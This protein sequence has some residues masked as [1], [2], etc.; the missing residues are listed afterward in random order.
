MSANDARIC[1]QGI[2][3]HTCLNENVVALEGSDDDLALIGSEAAFA[4][5]TPQSEVDI[6]GG[7]LH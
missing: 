4:K 5:D 2:G 1:P 3:E 7:L 6:D